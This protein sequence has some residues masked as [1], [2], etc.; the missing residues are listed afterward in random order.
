VVVAAEIQ[1]TQT[2]KGAFG[3]DALADGVG[4]SLAKSA[5]DITAVE[6]SKSLRQIFLNGPYIA[7]NN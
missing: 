1:D 7:A 6:A 3:S 5:V 2:A 4:N